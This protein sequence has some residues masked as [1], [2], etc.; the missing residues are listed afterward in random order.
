MSYFRSTY[1]SRDSMTPCFFMPLP[2]MKPW[3]MDTVRRMERRSPH[4]CATELLKVQHS[5]QTEYNCLRSVAMFKAFDINVALETVE[6]DLATW[7]CHWNA[8]G[9]QSPIYFI[10]RFTT[11]L[12]TESLMVMAKAWSVTLYI[13]RH[14]DKYDNKTIIFLLQLR[15]CR[16]LAACKMRQDVPQCSHHVNDLT[17]MPPIEGLWSNAEK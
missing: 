13:V 3:K 10:H 17:A 5:V 8:Q 7:R 14:E 2:Y 9:N 11:P 6:L 12:T 4:T 15:Q 16:W 1:L